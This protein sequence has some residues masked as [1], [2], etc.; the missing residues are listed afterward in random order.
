MWN[1]KLCSLFVIP[2]VFLLN[3]CSNKVQSSIAGVGYSSRSA[4]ISAKEDY[5]V[6]KGVQRIRVQDVSLAVQAVN[7]TIKSKGG[8]LESSSF[9][10]ASGGDHGRP[11][12]ELRIRV[13]ASR[14]E[15]TAD[16]MAGL[17]RE[18]YRC[19]QDQDV[20]DQWS[21]FE[22]KLKNQIALRDR[23]KALLKEAS[24][25]KEVLDIEKELARIQGEIDVMTAKFR[26]L[27]HEVRM[28]SLEL[29]IEQ[30]SIPGP[31]G[32][33]AKGIGWSLRKLF[34]LK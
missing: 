16:A 34:V 32:I 5:R 17:G 23:L 29:D 28:A 6:Q 20:T 4:N 7:E 2:A 3:S 18:T 27:Q 15:E 21:D 22:A 8:R 13:P 11:S 33:A 26:S 10:D 1:F 30:Q 25:V 19:I 24:T 12:A 9:R 14:L 31:A